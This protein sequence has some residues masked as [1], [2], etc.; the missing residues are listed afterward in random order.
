MEN[1]I[2]QANDDIEKYEN[3]TTIL[4]YFWK[5]KTDGKS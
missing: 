2:L 1:T 4:K 5:K 3:N